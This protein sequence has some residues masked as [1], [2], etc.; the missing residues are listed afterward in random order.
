CGQTFARLLDLRVHQEQA[1]EGDRPFRCKRC[2]ASFMRNHDLKRHYNLH[3]K[4][5]FACRGCSKTYTR[6]DALKRH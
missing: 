5:V 6:R 1:H 4:R 2:P 3:E